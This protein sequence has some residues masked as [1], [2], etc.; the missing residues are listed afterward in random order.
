MKKLLSMLLATLMVLSLCACGSSSSAPATTPEPTPAP[1]PTPTPEPQPEDTVITFSEGMKEF[2]FDK[3]QSCLAQEDDELDDTME[4]ELGEEVIAKFKEWAQEITYEVDNVDAAKEIAK[5]NVKYSYVDATNVALTFV[6]DY[7]AE[8]I[9]LAFSGAS[10]EEVE[11]KALEILITTLQNAETGSAEKT[12]SFDLVKDGDEWK[13]KEVPDE[14]EDVL[15]GNFTSALDDVNDEFGLSD[16][17]YDA[18]DAEQSDTV[19]LN[20]YTVKV[21]AVHVTKDS[22]GDP[23]AAVE[24]QY[25]NENAEPMSLMSCTNIK[26]FQNG[27]EL[28]KSELF[29]NRDY[30]W[31]SYYTEVKD[32][33]TITVFRALPLQN[34]DDPVEIYVDIYNWSSGDNATVKTV[35]DIAG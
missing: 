15:T 25:T 17:T 16:D 5:V 12:V 34:T 11:A 20:G 24:L 31:D 23:L 7:F 13:I 22:N 32:G 30:D 29:L 26:G 18:E 14:I 28:H 21:V 19:S 33:A 2:D 27:I 1:T 10:Q 9:N 3:M 8:A 35:F 4:A 6:S